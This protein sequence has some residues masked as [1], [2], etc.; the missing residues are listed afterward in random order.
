M[1]E[2]AGAAGSPDRRRGHPQ[3]AAAAAQI[4]AVAGRQSRGR[5][6]AEMTAADLAALRL[7]G[8]VKE[9]SCLTQSSSA[10]LRSTVRMPGS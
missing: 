3:L 4:G 5:T 8:A 10:G 7:P 2:P 1:S 9:I 6:V